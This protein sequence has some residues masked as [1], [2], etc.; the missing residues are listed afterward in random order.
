M[1]LVALLL[2]AVLALAPL[3]LS[4]RPGRPP[5]SRRESA[6]A[7]HRAQLLEL[8]RDQ[9]AGRIGEADRQFAVVEVQRRL[10]AAAETPEEVD[11]T[12]L[13]TGPPTGR[14]ALMVSLVLVP[15][16]AAGLYL[17]DGH[18]D[19]PAAPLAARL[20]RGDR[21]RQEAAA[22]VATLRARLATLDPTSDL[23][24]QGYQLLGNA[25]DGLGH[26]AAA[27][28]A[29]RAALA[30]RFDPNLAVE[31]AEAQTRLEGRVTPAS[32]ALF[33]RALSEAP[34]DAPWRRLAEQRLEELR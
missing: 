27:A 21:E 7:V 12:P 19:L 30:I 33:R 5:R 13:P 25:E 9:T 31:L 34:P 14:R 2:L 8:D 20:A 15:L 24:R 22:L 4:L 26:L 18:P 1:T 6:L 32:A 10:L 3:A 28:E 11:P 17:L 23:A 16:A 29:W